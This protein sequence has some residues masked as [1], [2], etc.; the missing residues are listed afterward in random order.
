MEGYVISML[1]DGETQVKYWAGSNASEKLDDA[2][3]IPDVVAARTNAANLQNQFTDYHVILLPAFKGIQ[4][5]NVVSNI[6][7][8]NLSI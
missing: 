2:T 7:S 1:R 5:R 3:F 4:L 8:A 6:Q